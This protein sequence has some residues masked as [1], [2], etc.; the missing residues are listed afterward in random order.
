MSTIR[1]VLHVLLAGT[2]VFF[3]SVT[4]LV[5]WASSD[6][7]LAGVIL[8]TLLGAWAGASSTLRTKQSLVVAAAGVALM[9]LLAL[10]G[11]AFNFYVNL[12]VLLVMVP[13]CTSLWLVV[14]WRRSSDDPP[15]A[16]T[17]RA[18]H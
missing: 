3:T 17:L 8:V 4:L 13:L 16:H 7:T 12:W 5:Q 6:C 2:Y 10:T 1:F 15:A 14:A 9:L 18:T 11:R